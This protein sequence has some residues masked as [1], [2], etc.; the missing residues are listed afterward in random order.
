[1]DEL[2]NIEVGEFAF[3]IAEAEHECVEDVGLAS[4]VGS[5]DGGEG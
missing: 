4:A 2:S 1:L 3:L 5:H